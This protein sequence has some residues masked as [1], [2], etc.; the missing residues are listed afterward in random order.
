MFDRLTKSLSFLSCVAAI[1]ASGVAVAA[2]LPSSDSIDTGS[3]RQFAQEQDQTQFRN[4][5]R[6]EERIN[7]TGDGAAAQSRNRYR[8][9]Q[10]TRSRPQAPVGGGQRNDDSAGSIS[11][12]RGTGQGASGRRM[13]GT[14]GGGRR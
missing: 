2:D 5:Q 9:E 7:G 3:S 11:G 8:Y 13:A 6:L 10:Q 4:R 12:G 14:G 1:L